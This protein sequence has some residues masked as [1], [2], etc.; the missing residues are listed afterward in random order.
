MANNLIMTPTVRQTTGYHP[1]ITKVDPD[2][3]DYLLAFNSI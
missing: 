3:N 1:E 2:L